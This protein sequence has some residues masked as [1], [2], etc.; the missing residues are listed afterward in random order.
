VFSAYEVD[1]ACCIGV[2]LKLTC[3]VRGWKGRR[4]KW[5]FLSWQKC[6][7]DAFL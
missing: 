6:E 1:C 4:K 5:W 7:G 2:E 3:S